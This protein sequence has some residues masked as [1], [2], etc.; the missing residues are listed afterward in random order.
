MRGQQEE[1]SQF[2]LHQREWRLPADDG[3]YGQVGARQH[4]M[5]N[6]T[7]WIHMRTGI[8]SSTVPNHKLSN[9]ALMRPAP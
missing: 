5:C 2:P 9:V 6:A 4:P 1:G 8:L 3:R 7:Q